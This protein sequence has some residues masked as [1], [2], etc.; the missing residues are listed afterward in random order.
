MSYFD[1]CQRHLLISPQPIPAV[2]ATYVD[3]LRY[4][5]DVL[6][7]PGNW[8]L[9]SYWQRS[10]GVFIQTPCPDHD[11]N[12]AVLLS[13]GVWT[14]LGAA[15]IGAH[16]KKRKG[17]EQSRQQKISVDRWNTACSALADFA[18]AKLAVV[19]AGTQPVSFGFDRGENPYEMGRTSVSI[20]V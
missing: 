13:I 15:W 9:D 1:A 7:M 6:C 8:I 5:F 4:F 18:A 17:I 14:L 12:I 16:V 3:Y 20:H 10:I 19:S 11:G 2:D